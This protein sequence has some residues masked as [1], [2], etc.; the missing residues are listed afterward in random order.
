MIVVLV[1]GFPACG[2]DTFIDLASEEYKCYR[3]S[4][5][6]ACK[7]FAQLM[8]WDGKKDTPLRKMLSDLKKLYA[9]HFDGPMSDLARA[10]LA[11]KGKYDFFFTSSREGKE[12]YRIKC[13]CEHNNI[14]FYYIFIVRKDVPAYDYG[15]DS[16]ND[17]CSST[18]VSPNYLCYNKWGDKEGYKEEVV[19]VMKDVLKK[20]DYNI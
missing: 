13:W 4:T 16:D 6:D 1:N 11:N 20:F 10:I 9:E 5:I 2:K 19:R 7:V 15:N 8:G 18:L 17:V 12:I 3:H 14:P